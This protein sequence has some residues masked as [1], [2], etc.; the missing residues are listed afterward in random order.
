MLIA[1]MACNGQGWGLG[2]RVGDPAGLSYKKYMDGNVLELTIGGANLFYDKNLSFRNFNNRLTTN[3]TVVINKATIPKG[4]QVHYLFQ[5]KLS[6]ATPTLQW[7]L[8]GGGQ[9]RVQKASYDFKYKVQNDTMWHYA[10]GG[11]VTDVDLGAD[12]VIGLE[13]SPTNIPISI[14][15]DMSLFL[16]GLDDP[17]VFVF[18]SGIGIRYNFQKIKVV[19]L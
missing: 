12:G 3:G 13:Y 8:G 11:M 1:T 5:K 17:F 14:F 2:P 10:T 9:F 19:P 6:Y 7:Y 18:Q 16:E 15:L 4:V